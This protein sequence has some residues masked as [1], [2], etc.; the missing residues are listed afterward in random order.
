M[1]DITKLRLSVAE[2]LLNVAF[3]FQRRIADDLAGGF[4]NASFCLFDAPFNL[5]FV[6]THDMLLMMNSGKRP[7]R[8]T[9]KAGQP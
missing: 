2:V 8:D 7:A 5:I 9:K 1:L 6:D 4:P 3:C